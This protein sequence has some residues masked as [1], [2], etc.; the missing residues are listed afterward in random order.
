MRQ[1][2]NPHAP[3]ERCTL[4]E[5]QPPLPTLAS[6]TAVAPQLS[7]GA[8]SWLPS[9]AAASLLVLYKDSIY[10]NSSLLLVSSYVSCHSPA[11]FDGE[12]LTC[13]PLPSTSQGDRVWHGMFAQSSPEM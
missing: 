1:G 6:E 2:E 8:A 12:A 9:A 7:Q 5:T 3:G 11:C 4:A 10:R 13:P